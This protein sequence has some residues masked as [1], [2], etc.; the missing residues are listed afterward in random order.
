MPRPRVTFK[1]TVLDLEIRDLEIT[2]GPEFAA[3][4]FLL[5][6]H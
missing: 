2:V 5:I 1:D 4:L 6:I 3:A